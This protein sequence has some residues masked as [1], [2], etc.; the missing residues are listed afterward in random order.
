MA[1]RERSLESSR[2]GNILRLMTAENGHWV[3]EALRRDPKGHKRKL[4]QVL[5]YF[6]ITIT[7][8]YYNLPTF[9]KVSIP[10]DAS[11][12]FCKLPKAVTRR[13]SVT[14]SLC[15]VPVYLRRRLAI[16]EMSL[17][18]VFSVI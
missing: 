12:R 11:V 3:A 8:K 14:R 13:W 10:N 16:H 7:L 15:A 1:M 17:E 18:L 4:N 5:R 6:I 2:Y 9:K